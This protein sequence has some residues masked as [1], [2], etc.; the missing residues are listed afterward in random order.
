MQPW[1]RR[2][3]ITCHHSAE[4]SRDQIVGLFDTDSGR[5]FISRESVEKLNPPPNHESRQIVTI[6][7][8]QKQSMPIFEVR[9]DGLDD[10]TSKQVE[11]TESKINFTTLRRPSIR[12]TIYEHT[13]D[14]QFYMAANEQY[15]IQVILGD[16]AYCEKKKT[17]QAF[18]GVPEE[19]TMFEWVI[20]WDYH[21]QEV[22]DR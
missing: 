22:K 10:R 7:G 9:L 2:S 4:D 15:P 21:A 20:H 14:K 5:N 6:N 19:G 17:N 8:V 13:C 18:K 12:A 11:I 16:S 1:L 3:I